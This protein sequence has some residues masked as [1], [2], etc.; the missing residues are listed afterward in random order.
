MRKETE[1]Y[2]PTDH[3]ILP[4]FKPSK[5][6]NNFLDPN[7][8]FQSFL[9]QGNFNFNFLNN[10]TDLQIAQNTEIVPETNTE[11]TDATNP[12]PQTKFNF[13]FGC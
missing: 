5:V 12:K 11:N 4:N 6:S 8:S 7:F 3:N 10:S 1:N 9:E 2:E 13:D